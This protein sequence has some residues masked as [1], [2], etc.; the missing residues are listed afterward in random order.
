MK[1]SIEQSGLLSL[2]IDGGRQGQ[3]HQGFC[4][5]G[6][7]DEEAYWWANYLVS[8]P[9]GSPCIESMGQCSFTFDDSACVAV[10]GRCVRVHIN[11]MES[12]PY[13]TLA[14]SAGDTILI[15][16]E[17]TGSKIYLAINGQWRV[18]SSINSA[19]TV[20]REHLG[21]LLNNGSALKN[22]EV[23]EITPHSSQITHK[24]LSHE[25][26]PC[27]DLD[28]PLAFIP[29]YQYAQFD[30][31]AKAQFFA[32][33]YTISTNINRM[34][35]RLSGAPV[36]SSISAMRSEGIHIGAM[37]IPPDGQPIVM[38]RDRQTLGGY[39]KLGSVSAL[40]INRLAQAVP[41][42]QVTFE[43]QNHEN[44]RAAY[45]MNWHKR[46][47]LTGEK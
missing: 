39:P 2:I 32:S 36:T 19:C 6:P 23:F 14:L 43:C 25:H 16:S 35:Y 33:E 7:M 15:D 37:Q 13:E 5:S 21:G 11:G 12:S 3:Q 20:M 45:L 40:D 10:T 27:Y 47:R 31:L 34:G 24:G 8:N 17:F 42:E 38:M 30:S 4:Q 44:A 1:V 26:W 41:N 18:P 28:K 9:Q 22:N 29:G 46:L